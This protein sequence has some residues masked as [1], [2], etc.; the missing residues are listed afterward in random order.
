M[1]IETT[2]GPTREDAARF[3]EIF[4]AL[5]SFEASQ[6]SIRGYGAFDRRNTP[7]PDPSVMRV[8]AWLK[9]R[10]SGQ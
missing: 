6:F 9:E 3:V 8:L 1:P 10:A 4:E 7:V 2:A 5:N